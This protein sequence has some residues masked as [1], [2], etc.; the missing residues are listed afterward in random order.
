MEKLPHFGNPVEGKT[1]VERKAVYR[2]Q[3]RRRRRV[4]ELLQMVYRNQHFLASARPRAVAPETSE[5]RDSPRPGRFLHGKIVPFDP[6]EFGSQKPVWEFPP[7]S[8]RMFLR[9][10]GGAW[11]RYRTM[12]CNSLDIWMTA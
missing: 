3:G 1:T 6:A 8:A 11:N 10:R 4:A 9:F 5:V 7:S 12:R 2:I